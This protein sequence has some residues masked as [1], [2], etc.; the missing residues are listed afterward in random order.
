[1]LNKF[2][3][4]VIIF[5]IILINSFKFLKNKNNLYEKKHIGIMRETAGECTLFLNKNNEFPLIKPCNVLLIGSGARNTVKGGLG[6]AD[7]ESR[8]YTTCEE[9]LEKAGFKITSKNWLNQYPLLKEKKIQEHINY[10]KNIH[11]INRVNNTFRMVSFP[12]YDYNLKIDQDAKNESDIAIYVL[13]RNSGEGIDRRLIKGDALLTD[14]EIKDILYLNKKFKKFILVLNVGG[15]VDLSPV[16]HVSNI[17]LLSQLGVV[18]GDILADIILGKVNPSGKLTTTWAKIDDYKFIKEFGDPNDT[19][20]KEG[21]YVGYRYFDSAGIKPLYPFGFGLSYTS[22][23]I[24]KVSLTNIK[25]EITIRIRVKNVGQFPGKEVIQV[26]ISPSQENIDKPYQSLVAFGKTPKLKPKKGIE[27]T[28]KF[29]LRNVAR[30]D[31]KTA[32]YTLDKGIYIIRVGNSSKNTRIYGYIKLIDNVILEELKNIGGTKDFEDYKPLLVMKDN[33]S[34]VQKIVLTKEDFE[35]KKNVNYNYEYK[36]YDKISKLNDSDLAYMCVGSFITDANE[37]NEKQRGLNALT[38]KKVKD[39]KKYLKMADGPS[40]LRIA[41][42]YKIEKKGYKIKRLSPNP[43]T[44][45]SYSYLSK[46]KKLSLI[47]DDKY[48]DYSNFTNVLYQYA[49]AIPIGTALAQTFNLDLVEKY[50]KVIGKEMELYSIDI[51]LGP[52]LNIHRNFLCGRNFEY[53][54]EDPLISGKMA[55]AFVRGVQSHKNKGTTLKHFA[56]NNQE[57]NRL[58]SNSIVSERALREIYLKGFQIAI[59]ESQPTALMTS[60]NLINGLHPSENEKLIIDIVRNEWKFQ[61]LI[62]TDWTKSGQMDFETSKNPPQYVYNTIKSGINIMMPGSQIDYNLILEK[63]NE[64][65]LTRDDLLYCA[66]K[67]FETLEHLNE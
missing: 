52:S 24:S 55:S 23:E 37:V 12:E 57:I 18:T 13:A 1:M 16:S 32:S 61:G 2:Y 63:L 33:L 56:A 43:A 6:S 38:T 65:V 59:E 28:L 67:V 39:I 15:V 47:N 9:G 22:F 29:K 8:F 30:Y 58:N 35:A 31:E 19:Y 7:V 51:L 20:Y 3:S 54:S 4:K 45:Y 27:M 60:D 48:K 42:V 66:S 36:I 17:L 44:I 64:K 46:Q 40:G 21:I 25:E 62:M 10:I 11:K 53:Y 41:K 5:T 50:G 49:T 26:Y 14:T 34:N